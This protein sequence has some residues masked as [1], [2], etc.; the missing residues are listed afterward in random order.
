MPICRL[1]RAAEP[2]NQLRK[3]PQ[4]V[5]F[6]FCFNILIESTSYADF[7]VDALSVCF[8]A[9]GAGIFALDCR[10][11]LARPRFQPLAVGDGDMAAAVADQACALQLFSRFGD[12]FAAHA[13]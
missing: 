11:T 5:L 3:Y 9:M 7:Y 8:A 2:G 1:C 12:A 4:L 6:C 13:Q 10:I